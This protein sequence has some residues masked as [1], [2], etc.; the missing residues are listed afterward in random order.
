MARQRG[1]T[2]AEIEMARK[3]FAGQ[4]T[5]GR[6][7]ISD[8]PGNNFAAQIAFA[9]GNPAITLGSTIYFK[10]DYCPDFCAT[11][12]DRKSFMH[13]MAHVWQYQR[14]GRADFLLRYGQEF[15]AV[16]GKP[17]DMY[18]YRRGVTKFS[19]AMLEAQASMIADYSE[20]LW[21]GNADQKARLAKNLEGSGVY[22]L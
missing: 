11:G 14:F 19:E 13:E 18:V 3:A 9:K 15:L 16:G 5:Y 12:K 1:L 8:G 4:I 7:K 17:N 2:S 6:V 10:R 20:A 21:T 22:G